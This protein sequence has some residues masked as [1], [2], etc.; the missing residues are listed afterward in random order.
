MCG[1]AGII[2]L[3]QQ[4]FEGEYHQALLTRMADAIWHRGPDDRALFTWENVGIA[5]NRLSIVD[6]EGGRQPFQTPNGRVVA[7]VNGEIYNHQELRRS[8]R[9]VPFRSRSDCE[10]IPFLYEER[11][12]AMF[13]DING[14]FAMVLLD[15]WER[16]LWLARDRLGIKPM[17]YCRSEDQRAFLFASEIKGL[18]AHPAAPRQFDWQAA[19]GRQRTV[20]VRGRLL[21]SYF[22]GIER[23]EPGS[24]LELCLDTGS[25]SSFQYWTIDTG[26]RLPD[27]SLYKTEDAVQ[28]FKHLLG[29]SVRKRT[30]GDVPF[31]VFLSGGIDS[32][33]VATL[34]AEETKS[35]PTFS[36]LSRSTAGNGD[37]AGAAA[38]AGY[39]GL[40][41]HQVFFD[42]EQSHIGCNEWRRILW[43]CEMF[44]VGGE[45]L[46]KFYL[47]QF[48]KSVY[49]DLKIILLGQ[50]SDEFTGGYLRT[51]LGGAGPWTEESWQCMDQ[52]LQ[53]HNFLRRA[54]EG[55]AYVPYQDLIR[56]GVLRPDFARQMAHHGESWPETSWDRYRLFYRHNLDY[57][58]WHEDR[59]SSSHS[60]ENRVPFLDHRLI[61]MLV[62][63]PARDQA[64]L[65]TDKAI[66]RHALAGDLPEEIIRRPK[67]EFFY[68][69]DERF[70][71]QL[72][73]SILRDEQDELIEQGL[74]GSERTHGPLEP[75][76]FRKHARQVG[77]SN[78]YGSVTRL[79][80][81]VN[82][83]V[84]ADL[85]VNSQPPAP[86]PL[87]PSIREVGPA[88]FENILAEAH[89]RHTPE[90]AGALVIKLA[91]DLSLMQLCKSGSA[92]GEQGY[93]FWSRNGWIESRINSREWGR[94]LSMVD[95]RKHVDR[96]IQE[97]N[98]DRA[99][100]VDELLASLE[101]NE[102]T[103]VNDGQDEKP[104]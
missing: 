84:L 12:R 25:T 60:I 34:A 104:S 70:T 41:N 15:R 72:M 88:E 31:G 37:A 61:E 93:Y 36:V 22:K 45:Q 42:L 24:V 21:P 51:L 5:F 79:F 86:Q 66:L 39:L 97:G 7:A 44:D 75:E 91:P 56:T 65:F 96:L 80:H 102:V 26:S 87:P 98:F 46:Y 17:F 23:V 16:R 9:S 82:M 47:H 18:L 85:A 64:G 99:H 4:P 52:R 78:T 40:A 49:P 103:L 92:S 6:L 81:L 73:Y 69:R 33:A 63:I 68:G 62:R 95:G 11:E 14:M 59:T 83:G 32:S 67:G 58:L 54:A 101:K 71:H 3:D 27:D 30:M 57:H 1:I 48:A 94:F 43:Q 13:D 2:H 77:Q 35:F 76:A 10:V 8:L 53:Y 89:N 29:D 19:L 50:G 74:R 55:G 20:D 28:E 90:Q 38:V 100:I